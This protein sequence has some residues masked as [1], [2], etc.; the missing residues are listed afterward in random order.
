MQAIVAKQVAMPAG[1]ALSWSGQFEYLE[2]ATERLKVVVPLTLAVIFMLLYV[3]FRSAGDAALVMAAVP[4]SL[5]GG[6]WFIWALGHAVSVASAVGF[7]AWP[8]LPP[9]LA[10]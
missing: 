9:S 8:A 3:L 7:I 4:F 10:S 5:V 2:R 1:Y 6:F